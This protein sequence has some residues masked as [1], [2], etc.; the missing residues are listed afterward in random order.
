MPGLCSDWLGRR[1]TIAGPYS[2][3]TIGGG[4]SRVFM[5][6]AESLGTTII[7]LVLRRE[8]EPEQFYKNY[9]HLQIIVK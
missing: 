3:N 2:G 4:G 7:K 1:D 5:F 8:G 9:H 6:K